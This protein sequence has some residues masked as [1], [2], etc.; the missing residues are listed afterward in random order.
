VKKLLTIFY[1]TIA[2]ALPINSYGQPT[3]LPT[4]DEKREVKVA[5]SDKTLPVLAEPKAENLTDEQ[6]SAID[7][8]VDSIFSDKESANNKKLEVTTTDAKEAKKEDEAPVVIDKSILD[9]KQEVANQD[10]T[11]E[12][13]KIFN[14][15]SLFEETKSDSNKKD[16]KKVIAKK[17]K[18]D[19]K[20]LDKEIK[21]AI[22]RKAKKAKVVEKQVEFKATEIP[23]SM[24]NK[25]P[26]LLPF[27][28][29]NNIT[30]NDDFSSYNDQSVYDSLARIKSLPTRKQV[31]EPTSKS[32]AKPA[33]KPKNFYMRDKD[34]K[35]E[36]K[37]INK[38][39][40]KYISLAKDAIEVGQYE[41][42]I[43]YYKEL[44]KKNPQNKKLRFGLATSYHKA[45]QYDNARKAYLETIKMDKNYWP[46]V[47]NY[48]ILISE[49][50]PQNAEEELENLWIKNPKFAGIPA[51]LGNIY[52]KKKNYSKASEYYIEAV[53]L[54]NDNINYLYNLAIVL[55][56]NNDKKS[57]AQVY[58][59]IAEYN[60]DEFRLPESKSDL[61]KR[62][63][64]LV[65]GR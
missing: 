17:I 19:Q 63:Y 32:I 27:K 31:L 10:Q 55:E 28:K 53:K 36:V 41:S 60:G 59:R 34:L 30:L 20:K 7:N 9:S 18:I 37:S 44:V 39:S 16:K 1:L 22:N 54:D 2:V 40:T 48:I 62:Y 23:A 43:P 5:S 11:E 45:K 49:E 61:M 51:Q 15:T 35:V 52:Y 64:S 26:K 33:A 14:A 24:Q 47:N 57:A 4:L 25:S 46:A 29:S 21:E 12:K 38:E 6:K 56:N 8:V 50:K 42:A 13:V 58:K 3:G 65:S